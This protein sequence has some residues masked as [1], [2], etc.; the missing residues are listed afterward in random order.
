MYLGASIYMYNLLKGLSA[1]NNEL[2]M[3]LICTYLYAFFD[4]HIL[5]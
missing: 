2:T 3:T 5:H 4:V 1:L